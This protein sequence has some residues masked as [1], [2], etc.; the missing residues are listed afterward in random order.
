[1]HDREHKEILIEYKDLTRGRGI[2]YFKD[3]K[4]LDIQPNPDVNNYIC[5]NKLI[6][7]DIEQI[8][9]VSDIDHIIWQGLPNK[10]RKVWSPCDVNVAF[11][12]MLSIG[13]DRLETYICHSNFVEGIKTDP[14]SNLEPLGSGVWDIGATFESG[15]EPA[16]IADSACRASELLNKIVVIR[17]VFLNGSS[18]ELVCD[19]Y[20]YPNGSAIEYSHREI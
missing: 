18:V 15:S 8:V 14:L 17:N 6:E 1:M 12:D 4:L 9:L 20:F 7:H 13:S 11:A 19:M 3:G 5:V 10:S 16:A 2:G